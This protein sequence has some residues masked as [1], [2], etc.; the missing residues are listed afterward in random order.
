MTTIALAVSWYAVVAMIA[1]ASTE[2]RD[3]R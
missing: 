2:Y 1:I 3:V